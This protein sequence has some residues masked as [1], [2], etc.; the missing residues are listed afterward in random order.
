M[1]SLGNL[2]HFGHDSNPVAT[3]D[4]S[5]WPTLLGNFIK[6]VKIFHFSTEI[7][8]WTTFIDIWRLF[9][10]HTAPC[11]ILRCSRKTSFY[12]VANIQHPIYFYEATCY[13]TSRPPQWSILFFRSLD[14]NLNIVTNSKCENI[15]IT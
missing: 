13:P 3:I 4:L 1:T 9:T 10:G 15:F 2:L 11:S 12:S 7:I 14:S 6:G 5:K 8:Y